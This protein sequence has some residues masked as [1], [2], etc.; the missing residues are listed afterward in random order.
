MDQKSDYIALFISVLLHSLLI[1]LP[2]PEK[3]R[4]LAKSPTSTGPISIIFDANQLPASEAQTLPS[5]APIDPPVPE[6]A[7]EADLPPEAPILETID[8]PIDPST[9]EA[10]SGVAPEVDLTP[11]APIPET[12]DDPIDPS[13]PEATS[14][15]DLTPEAPIPATVDD[16]IDQP[17]PEV[18]PEVD[19]TP[20]IP[21]PATVD[22]PI[23]Q[24]VPEVAPASDLTPEVPISETSDSPISEAKIAA[25]WENLVGYL[26]NQDEGF[27][28]TLFEIFDLFGETGQAN[29]F[30][31][32]NNQP[33]LDVSSFSHF[34]EQTPEQVLQT[35]VIPE[36]TNN[37]GFELQPQENVSDGLA[38]QLS[39]GEMLRYLIIA[40]LNERSGSVLMLSDSLSG[41]ESQ[42]P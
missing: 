27:G 23:D 21:I 14:E 30:F 6:V 10:A 20:E 1:F 13:T 7:P 34:P 28:F 19:S 24:P 35:V 31:D 41:L 38:Y 39:Q 36:L 15:V 40:R 22:D 32:E 42:M 3:P 5:D 29:Q 12:V 8:S 11:E 17:V 18:A 37:T 26:E 4:P 16:P 9:P 25:D 33:K 2:W